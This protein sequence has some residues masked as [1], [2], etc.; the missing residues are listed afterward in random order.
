MLGERKREYKMV[1]KRNLGKEGNM[2]SVRTEN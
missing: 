2:K 1:G